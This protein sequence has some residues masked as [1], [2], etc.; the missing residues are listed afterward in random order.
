DREVALRICLTA[1][2]RFPRAAEPR[3]C[4]AEMAA[5]TQRARMPLAIELLEEGIALAPKER[6]PVELLVR[7]KFEWLR[8][9]MGEERTRVDAVLPEA[10]RLVHLI[11]SKQAELGGKP[12][13]PDAADI[14]LEIAQGYYNAGAPAEAEQHLSRSLERRPTWKAHHQLGLL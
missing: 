1:A 9:H 11:E 13:E 14:W 6:P 2:D 3:F 10:D 8:E 5:Y 4:A 7:L 12:I